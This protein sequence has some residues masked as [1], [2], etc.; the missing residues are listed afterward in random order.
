MDQSNIEAIIAILCVYSGFAS[1]IT[2]AI[3]IILYREK[4]SK[5]N[6]LVHPHRYLYLCNE[7]IDF[8]EIERFEILM[9]SEKE[10]RIIM[11]NHD[12]YKLCLSPNTY[13]NRD[14]K[15]FA[16][17]IRYW[18][19]LYENKENEYVKEK[20]YNS[21]YLRKMNY[22]LFYISHRDLTQDLEKEIGVTTDD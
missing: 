4:L 22:S 20:Y 18:K 9:G 6:E 8:S 12:M 1:T 21:K 17:E 2:L 11:K 3:S 13:T 14:T 10:I 16:A 7:K 15:K 19:E 5:K